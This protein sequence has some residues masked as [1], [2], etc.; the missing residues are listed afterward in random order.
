VEVQI[1]E[2]EGGHIAIIRN[3]ARHILNGEALLMPGEEGI[4]TIEIINS[5]IL[6]GKKGTPVNI[7]VDREEYEAF[8]EDLKKTTKPKSS[9]KKQ[10]VTDPQ[11]VK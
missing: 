5:V 4:N 6:S 2:R 3:L 1:E 10:K 7:P 8:L 9:L 11:H